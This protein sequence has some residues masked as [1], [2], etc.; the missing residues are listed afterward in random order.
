MRSRLGCSHDKGTSA[1]E[2]FCR[3]RDFSVATDFY[4]SQKKIKIKKTHGIW[5]VTAWYQSI[6]IRIPR[7][8]GYGSRSLDSLSSGVT[9]CTS[10][11]RYVIA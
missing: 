8:D 4:E 2:V 7:N 6:G 9:V 11:H 5:G 10:E 1:T 3:D